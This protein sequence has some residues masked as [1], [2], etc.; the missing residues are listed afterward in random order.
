MSQ[1]RYWLKTGKVAPGKIVTLWKFKKWR[2]AEAKKL[3]LDLSNRRS[4][5]LRGD[6][7]A[8][9]QD[10]SLSG[11]NCG[12]AFGRPFGFSRQELA[13]PMVKKMNRLLGVGPS[14]WP[15]CRDGD[16]IEYVLTDTI[17]FSDLAVYRAHGRWVCHR[18]IATRRCEGARSY[19]L[20][21]D[22]KPY[23]DGWIPSFEVVGRVCRVNGKSV[24][25][26]LGKLLRSEERRVGKES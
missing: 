15:L 18:V 25:T 11:R 16:C 3:S 4:D 26:F 1:I 23:V 8:S 12:A 5:A 20:K 7:S 9:P 24:D 21:G 2:L 10:T 6:P 19:L 17:A 22:A 14:Q 13:K